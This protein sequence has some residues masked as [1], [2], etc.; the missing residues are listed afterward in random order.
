MNFSDLVRKTAETADVSPKVAKSV[1]EGAIT[2]IQGQLTLGSDVTL[3]ALGKLVVKAKPARKARN[4]R[5]G[6]TVDVPA[7]SVVDFKPSAALKQ[8]V[9]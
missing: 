4:P 8:A 1:L 3:G 7:H 2:T 9:A 6:E 5:T